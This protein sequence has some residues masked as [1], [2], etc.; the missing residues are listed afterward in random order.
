MHHDVP[1]PD[2]N[3]FIKYNQVE[4]P[5]YDKPATYFDTLLV[6]NEKGLV[7]LQPILQGRHW[8]VA[9][10]ASEHGIVLPIYGSMPFYID[11]D[12]HPV[13]DTIIYTFE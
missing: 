7:T 4:F 3:V 6:S 10:G 5:G 12:S 2:V 8:A 9:F 11:L 1:V 13:V